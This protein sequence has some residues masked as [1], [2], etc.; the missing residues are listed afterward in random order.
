MAPSGLPETLTFGV[1]NLGW[2]A[3]VRHRFQGRE[4]VPGLGVQ[5]P[6][7]LC[8]CHLLTKRAQ[9]GLRVLNP[10]RGSVSHQ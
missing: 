1:E 4:P 2:R 8:F 10:D 3:E 5:L 7:W 6:R 9:N